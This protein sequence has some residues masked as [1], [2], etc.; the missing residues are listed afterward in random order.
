MKIDGTDRRII[1]AT[2]S[3]LPLTPEPYAVVAAQL[4]LTVDEVMA[5][6]E[7]A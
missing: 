2:Q 1:A 4:G 7:A 3:G 5:R 6:L